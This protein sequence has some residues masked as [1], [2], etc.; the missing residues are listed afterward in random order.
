MANKLVVIIPKIKKML[1]YEMKF[2]VPNYSCL[3]NPW[4]VGYRPQIPILSVLSWICWPPRTKFL[5]TPLVGGVFPGIHLYRFQKPKTAMLLPVHPDRSWGPP[6]LLINGFPGLFPGNKAAGA[7]NCQS[8]HLAP[9]SKKENSYTIP[10]PLSGP[11][12]LVL[13]WTLP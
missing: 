11:S 7:W 8:A 13:S 6:I 1:L 4:L 12:W 5:G 9:K 10:L 2:I 3:Q